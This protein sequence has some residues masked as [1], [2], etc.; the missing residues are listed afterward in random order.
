MNNRWMKALIT[1]VDQV[2]HEKQGCVLLKEDVIKCAD[3]GKKLLN[4]IKVKESS[5][6]K[7]IEALCP[8][9]SG[10]SFLYRV[11]GETFFQAYNK[12]AIDDM[13]VDTI[14]NI[15]KMKVKVIK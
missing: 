3:C 2:E 6:I 11:E 10:S 15:T 5:T 12:L 13:S 1:P 8:Y 14:D 7:E 9:C 4:I